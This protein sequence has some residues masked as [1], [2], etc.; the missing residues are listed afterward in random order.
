MILTEADVDDT[1]G[2]IGDTRFECVPYRL[3]SMGYSLWSERHRFFLLGLLVLEIVAH[4][5][6]KKIRISRNAVLASTCS[7]SHS[8]AVSSKHMVVVNC[9]PIGNPALGNLL[10]CQFRKSENVGNNMGLDLSASGGE[11]L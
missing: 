1:L 6:Q 2:R 10:G 11:L 4:L 8:S 9:L 5:D 7:T 3:K